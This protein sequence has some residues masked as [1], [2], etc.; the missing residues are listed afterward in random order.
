MK[1]EY[2]SLNEKY[3]NLKLVGNLKK[4]IIIIYMF[5]VVNAQSEDY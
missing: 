1:L 4:I 5:I 3:Y 2:S